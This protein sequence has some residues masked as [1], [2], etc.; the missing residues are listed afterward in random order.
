MQE[1]YQ[2][3]PKQRR[4]EREEKE[5]IRDLLHLKVN[6]K[7]LQQNM[8]ES[9]GKVITLRDISN[10]PTGKCP[11]QD[12]NNLEAIITKL[13]DIEGK[14]YTWFSHNE[15]ACLGSNVDI[16]TDD[17]NTLTGILFQDSLMKSSFAS[18]PEVLL[19]DATYKLN[20]LRMPLYLM[21]VLDS[22]GQSEIVATFLTT[23][24]TEIAITKMVKAFKTH[25]SAWTR[26]TAILSDKDFTEWNVFI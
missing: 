24:E 7:L 4:L 3:L 2:H 20:E 10:V 17:S 26:T 5:K 16:F 14:L 23:T 19:I 22:N 13:K 12:R 11:K 15:S 8:T 18:Y 21:I 25:N 9:T 6:K 1:V